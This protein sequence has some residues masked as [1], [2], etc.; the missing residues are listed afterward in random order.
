[1]SDRIWLNVWQRIAA[2]VLRRIWR[3]VERRLDELSS[4]CF[5]RFSAGPMPVRFRRRSLT[6]FRRADAH[7]AGAITA[8]L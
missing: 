5:C 4:A 8:G 6:S 2:R 7:L 3:W 1:M